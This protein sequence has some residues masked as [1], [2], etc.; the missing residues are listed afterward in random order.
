MAKSPMLVQVSDELRAAIKAEAATRKVS[1]AELV[2]LSVA[3]EINYDLSVE[4]K[5]GRPKKYENAEARKAAVRDKAQRKRTAWKRI[6]QMMATD[7]TEKELNDL[8]Q[9]LATDLGAPS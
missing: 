8:I 2:R 3:K 7:H 4:P 6:E 1:A 5:T 9:S